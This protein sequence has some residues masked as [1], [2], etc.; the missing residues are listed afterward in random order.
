[1]SLAKLKLLTLEDRT[2]PTVLPAGFGETVLTTQITSPTA[3]MP[4]PDGR[5]F[6]AEQPG[7]LRLFE[8][9]NL[10]TALALTVDSRGERG[11]LG[12]ALD[13]A[14][15]S[16]GFVY[17]YYTVPGNSTTAP[18][19]RVS[20][21]TFDGTTLNPATEQILVNLD[22]LS[23]ATNHNGG[24]LN[25]GP[26][27][28]LYV[29]TGENANPPLA[30]SLGTRHGKILRYNPDGTIP[31]DNPTSFPGISGSTT[32]ANRAIWAVG[33]RNPFTF[34]V[35][36][37]NGNLF[38]ND[39]GQ[40]AREELNI[41]AGG[42]NYGWPTTEG[43]FDPAAFPNFTRPAF[44]YPHV[45]GNDGGNAIAGAT[46]YAP[47]NPTFPASYNGDFF[48]GDFTNDWLRV[49]DAATGAVTLFAT[50][51]TSTG[52]VDLRV[53]PAGDLLYLARGNAGNQPAG[54]YRLR[55][56]AAPQ[57]SV[58]P[59][60]VRTEPGRPVSLTVAASGT[61]APNYQ[62]ERNGVAIPGANTA[63][64][65]LTIP[66]LADTG[67]TFRVIVTNEAG[68]VTSRTATL[69][70][71][72]NQAPTVT[73]DTPLA[74]S[75]FSGGETIPFRGSATDPE[76]GPLPA[77]NLTWRV[78][79]ITGTAP[80]RPLVP[81]TTGIASGTFTIP[82]QTPYTATDVAYVIRLTA[83]DSNGNSTTQ[84]R[85]ILPRTQAFTVASSPVP[86]SGF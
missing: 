69:T 76:D 44:N 38:I 63:T 21:F 86:A 52:L 78:D 48:F 79:Y 30:Q 12:I 39:V 85:Q 2:T 36:A 19:N 23:G 64:L 60:N 31:A 4:L 47:V 72:A 27:G 33:L 71:T 29:A 32:G 77:A 83:T 26:D 68:S 3:M 5:L 82:I 46:I 65:I 25:F 53:T 51:L 14:F 7:Q 10:T 43:D 22:N 8:N 81:D 28:K 35:D 15:N 11:L 55:F 17:L 1:M 42:A 67:A 6:I 16:N 45:P 13:P 9:G 58:E 59:A 20:R 74:D 24:A 62:W 56:T 37:T 57:I 40:A 66:T 70:V 61:P 54:V 73:I 80:P 49:R 75:F 41:G 34:T 84:T 18:F 50:D